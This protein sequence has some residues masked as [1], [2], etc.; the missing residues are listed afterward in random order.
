M[1]PRKFSLAIFVLKVVLS[2]VF[3][4]IRVLTVDVEFLEEKLTP[5]R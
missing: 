1:Q 4:N 2:R 5:R 3:S